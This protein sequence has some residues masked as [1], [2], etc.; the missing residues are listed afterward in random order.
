[1]K[2]IRIMVHLTGVVLVSPFGFRN[3]VH[4]NPPDVFLYHHFPSLAPI[5][6]VLYD[7]FWTRGDPTFSVLFTIVTVL[8][9]GSMVL[10]LIGGRNLLFGFSRVGAVLT[11]VVGNPTVLADWCLALCPPPLFISRIVVTVIFFPL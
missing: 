9:G 6:D 8:L 4:H 10:E 11:E 7:R 5:F 3:H 2:T 1:M